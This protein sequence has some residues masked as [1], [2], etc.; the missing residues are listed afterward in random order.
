MRHHSVCY[1]HKRPMNRKHTKRCNIKG[2]A[3]VLIPFRELSL[4]SY[5]K[6]LYRLGKRHTE[7]FLKSVTPVV[8]GTCIACC[9][10]QPHCLEPSNIIGR[11]LK[12]FYFD[13]IQI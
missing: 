4:S 6:S 10:V 3:E 5:I 8:I 9:K 13:G 2:P 1:F 12:T 7:D 11:K